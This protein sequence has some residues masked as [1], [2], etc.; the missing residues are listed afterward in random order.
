MQYFCK[1]EEDTME[2]QAITSFVDDE[3]VIELGKVLRMRMTE[4]IM[5]FATNEATICPKRVSLKSRTCTRTS[6]HP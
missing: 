1:E 6:G 4:N 2:G 5:R 3:N